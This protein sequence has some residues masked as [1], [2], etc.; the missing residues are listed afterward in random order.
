M[1][2]VD[3]V[4]TSP[5]LLAP[6]PTYLGLQGP[7]L[8][9]ARLRPDLN[10]GEVSS[11]VGSGTLMGFTGPLSLGVVWPDQGSGVNAAGGVSSQLVGQEEK[12]ESVNFL[13]QRQR[14]YRSTQGPHQY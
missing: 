5:L 13:F 8:A 7:L 12:E 4:V 1:V 14:K 2:V 3:G 9:R 11:C 6:D 10:H